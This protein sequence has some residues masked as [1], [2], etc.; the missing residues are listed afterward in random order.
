M[1]LHH[2]IDGTGRPVVLL[3]PV[4]LDLTFLQ[5]LAVRLASHC[6]VMRMDLRGH[7]RSPLTPLARGLEDFA[8]DVHETG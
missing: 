4:G 5:P 7:G 1:I 3:H 6:R 8:D 2:V